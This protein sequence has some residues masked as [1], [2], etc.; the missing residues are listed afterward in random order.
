M[1]GPAISQLWKA[2]QKQKRSKGK[3]REREREETVLMLL[4]AIWWVEWVDWL[5][6]ILATCVTHFTSSNS[7]LACPCV[8]VWRPLHGSSSSF[9]FFFLL[10]LLPPPLLLLLCFFFSSSCFSSHEETPSGRVFFLFSLCPVCESHGQVYSLCNASFPICRD[11]KS[12][13]RKEGPSK[14]PCMCLIK[15][16]DATDDSFLRF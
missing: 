14:L 1:H 3:V 13:E 6:H 8:Y 2:N 16:Q 5:T 9:V 4:S 12:R 11:T 10:L 15:L 7:L